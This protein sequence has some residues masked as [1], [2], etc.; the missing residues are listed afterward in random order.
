MGT[1]G[2]MVK[3]PDITEKETLTVT[4]RGITYVTSEGEIIEYPG[5]ITG[6]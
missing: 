5:I 6:M 3:D 2:V 1:T 4:G